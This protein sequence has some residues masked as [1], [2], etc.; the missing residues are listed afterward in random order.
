[1]DYQKRRL[2]LVE[3][4]LLTRQN[5]L[6]FFTRV[7]FAQSLVFSVP[8]LS[9]IVLYV[10][11]ITPSDYPGSILITKKTYHVICKSECKME[12]CLWK[13]NI[14]RFVYH[15]RFGNRIRNSYR[16]FNTRKGSLLLHRFLISTRVQNIKTKSSLH[17]RGN[18]GNQISLFQYIVSTLGKTLYS[19]LTSILSIKINKSLYGR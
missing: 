15:E 12:K 7:C 1:M 9:V 17:F 14:Y 3:Q 19:H 5:Y 2:P 8:F 16:F 11:W 13:L 10:L 6:W 4:E 18:F